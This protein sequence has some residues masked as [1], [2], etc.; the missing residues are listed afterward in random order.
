[1]IPDGPADQNL[2]SRA[3]VMARNVDPRG[4]TA[5]PGGVDKN[6]VRRPRLTTLVSPVMIE[7]PLRRRSSA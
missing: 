2:I 1:M 6:L 4:N 3:G 5:D 7:T